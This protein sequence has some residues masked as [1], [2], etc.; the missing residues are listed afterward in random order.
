MSASAGCVR[1]YGVLYLWR[2][3][4]VASLTL[5]FGGWERIVVV[6][7][8]L[9]KSRATYSSGLQAVSKKPITSAFYKLLGDQKNKWLC[10]C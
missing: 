1:V 6:R 9:A 2:I 4:R 10:F 7:R 5:I 8:G 3:L